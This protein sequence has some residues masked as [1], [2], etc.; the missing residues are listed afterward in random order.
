LSIA[1]VGG[2]AAVGALTLKRSRAA[3]PS[4]VD[5]HQA[6]NA[7]AGAAD[8][9]RE[10][11]GLRSELARLKGEVAMANARSPQASPAPAP[12]KA[13]APEAAPRVSDNPYEALAARAAHEAKDGIW[14]DKTEAQINQLISA[15]PTPGTRFRSVT[16]RT[17]LCE[18]T[19][20]SDDPNAQSQLAQLIGTQEPFVSGGG[21]FY[22]YQQGP[23]PVTTVYMLRP[24]AQLDAP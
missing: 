7:P 2:L 15:Q 20:V 21:T 4:S 9:G 1:S 8:L 24:G 19:A 18:V 10:L 16:C 23:H 17:S 5:D 3:E 13:P 12:A 22:R 11:E 14:S 6:E